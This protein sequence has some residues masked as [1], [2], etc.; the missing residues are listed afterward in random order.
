M[1]TMA[2]FDRCIP[3]SF[4]HE[5]GTYHKVITFV[6]RLIIMLRGQILT[7]MTQIILIMGAWHVCGFSLTFFSNPCIPI[8]NSKYFSGSCPGCCHALFIQKP[9]TFSARYWVMHH[10]KVGFFPTE[11]RLVHNCLKNSSSTLSAFFSPAFDTRRI[12]PLKEHTRDET[13][14]IKG[15]ISG[16]G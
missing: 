7:V 11:S 1:S 3:R 8:N 6:S 9:A 13:E 16:R 2:W 14:I 5:H 12:S 15:L 10:V 4:T